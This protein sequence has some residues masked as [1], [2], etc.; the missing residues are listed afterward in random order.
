MSIRNDLSR[1]VSSFLTLGSTR[2][3]LFALELADEKQR[4]INVIVLAV[5]VLLFALLGL[6]MASVAVTL[7]FWDTEYRWWALF[8]VTAFH[9]LAALIAYFMLS[10]S[11]R[12]AGEA[13]AN[14]RATLCADI[15][16]FSRASEQ[17]WKAGDGSGLM[18][19]NVTDLN[20]IDTS[21]LQDKQGGAS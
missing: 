11:S 21:T 15:E 8:G 16:R 1:F 12:G 4:W 2:A 7:F 18:P 6:I 5:L 9:F 13:F 3:K 10:S 14:T 17:D 19:V 20:N